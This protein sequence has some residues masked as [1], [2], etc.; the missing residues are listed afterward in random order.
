MAAPV[1]NKIYFAG[2][3]MNI[4]GHTIAVHGASESAYLMLEQILKITT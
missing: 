2:E 1:A 4:K 3:A